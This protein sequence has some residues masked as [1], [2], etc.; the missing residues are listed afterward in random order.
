MRIGILLGF[1]GG[2]VAKTIAGKPGAPDRGPVGMIRAH[3]REAISAGKEAAADKEEEIRRDYEQ[4]TR[5]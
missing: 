1:L 2:A 4:K 5:Q 3:V